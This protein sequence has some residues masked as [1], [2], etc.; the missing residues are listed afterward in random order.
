MRLPEII[1][2]IKSLKNHANH[3]SVNAICNYLVSFHD[4]FS[5]HMAVADL[6]ALTTKFKELSELRPMDY[7]T[8]TFEN[9]YNRSY[10]LLVFYLE[11]IL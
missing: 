3:R 1:D 9:D 2:E 8:E 7:K 4:Q 6:D 11:R 5:Q 10:G